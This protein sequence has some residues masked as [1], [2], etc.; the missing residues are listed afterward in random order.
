MFSKSFRLPSDYID[1]SSEE[2]SL[3]GESRALTQE[4]PVQIQGNIVSSP[5]TKPSQPSPWK[6][7]KDE[8]D[9]NPNDITKWD[10]LFKSFNEKFEELYD[11]QNK[12]A[13]N[14][15]FKKFVHESY[16]ELLQRFPYLTS[17]WKDFLIFEYKLNGV[18]ASIDILSKSVDNFPYSIDLWTDYMSALITQYEG[19]EEE[20]ERK[21]QIDFIRSQFD[22]ALKYNGKQF[23]SHPLWDKLIEFESTINGNEEPSKEILATCLQVIRIPLY[24]Y[25]QYYNRFVEINKLFS[26]KHI[27]SVDPDRE[28][29]T[30]E[31]LNRFNKG[32]L[33]ELSTIEEHQIIDDFSYKIF[34]STQ[35][36]VNQKWTF[37]SAISLP[38]FSLHHYSQIEKE[39][40]N[41][42]N[43]LD[44]EITKYNALEE[45]NKNKRVQFEYVTNLF[46][47][48]LIPN[49]LNSKFWL[50]YLAFLNSLHLQ[51]QEKYDKMKS[52]YDLAINRFI[53]LDDNYIRFNYSLFFLK[54][55]R[56]DLSN[57]LLFDL[58]KLFGGLG[59]SKLY[60][61]DHYLQSVSSLIKSW[62]QSLE[63][64]RFIDTIERIID[65]YFQDSEKGTK[66]GTE[67]NKESNKQIDDKFIFDENYIKILEKLLNDESICVI[68]DFYLNYLQNNSTPSTYIKIRKFFNKYHREPAVQKSVRFWK[69]YIE[70]E[71]IVHHNVLNLRK[72]MKTI[73]NNTQLPKSIIDGFTDL[74]YDI[75]TANLSTIL[76]NNA[77]TGKIDDTLIM[78]DNDL[79]DSLV[80][81]SSARKRL[82]NNNYLIQELE[83]A[84]IAKSQSRYEPGQPLVNREEELLKIV[85]KHA[86][87]P[88]IVVDHTP[89][90]SNKLMNDGNWIS[91]E[92]DAI[93]VPNFPTFK[94]VEK[95]SLPMVYPLNDT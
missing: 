92:G 64:I 82:S 53:P 90:I 48:S 54:Y 78:Y 52:I 51:T 70:Y 61:K 2:G 28:S 87:H 41:W 62:S 75:V 72:I 55:D 42:I 22:M 60:Q 30:E 20:S 63:G 12:Q 56:F 57:E 13:I 4:E 83:D 25:A 80:V 9:Q 33:D 67:T 76:D 40:S 7:L 44:H 17:Y 21:S 38:E 81:N 36:E 5:T 49:C 84:K 19:L 8:V 85:R 95:A 94:N 34:T 47:R 18:E 88:G 45:T 1:R 79:S 65:N 35:E 71:G 26:I 39:S 66:H 14:D 91:L 15:T 73:Q 24:Q 6:P 46:E 31:Y 68:I 86:D 59:T 16:S 50:K 29:L 27:F 32:S 89:E 23:L 43:Y 37:E 58:I 74:N 77:N 93:E 3:R 11:D 10:L 69:F